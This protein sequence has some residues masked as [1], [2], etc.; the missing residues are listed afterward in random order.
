[1]LYR[2]LPPTCIDLTSISKSAS[3]LDT[4]NNSTV[5]KHSSLIPSEAE[6]RQIDQKQLFNIAFPEVV[7][8]SRALDNFFNLSLDKYQES[9]NVSSPAK[10]KKTA[11]K[12][13]EASG[14]DEYNQGFKP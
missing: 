4:Q 1:M 11:D 10:R 5:A 12:S 7:L 9:L 6:P 2:A 3:T 14:T 8:H 13:S